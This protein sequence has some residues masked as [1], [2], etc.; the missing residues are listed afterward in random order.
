M[1][2][3]MMRTYIWNML[4]LLNYYYTVVLWELPDAN[5][6]VL[7]S[8]LLVTHW[9]WLQW[10]WQEH[11]KIWDQAIVGV[12]PP[13]CMTSGL[14]R[15]RN[16]PLIF[17]PIVCLLGRG[18]IIFF[19]QGRF[20]FFVIYFSTTSAKTIFNGYMYCMMCR[21]SHLPFILLLFFC[22]DFFQLHC[23]CNVSFLSLPFSVGS[24]ALLPFIIP[25][26]PDVVD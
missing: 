3:T 12:R 1:N 13:N 19:C 17:F 7:L 21:I 16:E 20:C 11:K 6:F 26:W 23:Y 15:W 8:Q 18:I 10:S 9:Q 5:L 24:L 2:V 25:I 14:D 4:R 22:L